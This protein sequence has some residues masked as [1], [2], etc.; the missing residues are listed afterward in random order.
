MSVFPVPV[1]K[2]IREPQDG[3]DIEESLPV[4]KVLSNSKLLQTS[5]EVVDLT[6]DDFVKEFKSFLNNL[7]DQRR[8]IDTRRC[9][10]KAKH[11]KV[12]HIL[13]V[14]AL[15]LD[16]VRIHQDSFIFEL[17]RLNFTNI[18]LYGKLT[19]ETFRDDV[20]IYQ[21]D[22]GT[23]MVDVYY[24]PSNKT[25]LDN[26]NKLNCCEET[27]RRKP[28]PLNE[29]SVPESLELRRHLKLLISIAKEQCHM[30]LANLKL[31]TQCFAIGHPFTNIQGKASVFAETILPDTEVGNS[32]ELFWKSYLLSQ[33][34][35]LLENVNKT[36][37]NT[38]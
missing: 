37:S 10:T 2:I 1:D 24:R 17:F 14:P 12:K 29:E 23:A 20:K 36:K 15:L 31:R 38:T 13:C 21:I 7:T 16:H 18:M 33:F 32:C 30:H 11:K 27:L 3:D 25:M 19:S 34:E 26:L 35:P 6:Q 28:S 5:I 22:D 8:D 9:S 4:F